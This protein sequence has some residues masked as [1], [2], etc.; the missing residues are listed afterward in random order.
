MRILYLVDSYYPDVRSPTR[1]SRDLTVE[2][3]TQGH[4]VTLMTPSSEQ[5]AALAI[6]QVD[7]VTIVRVRAGR[8][9]GV[10]RLRRAVN[11]VR[12]SAVLWR[13]AEA[14]FRANPHDLVISYSPTIFFGDLVRRLKRLW[15]ARSYLILRDIF[16]QWAA[17]AGILSER[18]PIYRFFAAK[19]EYQYRQADVIGVQSRGDL[20]F[21]R[22]MPHRVEVLY[23][24]FRPQPA[25][26]SGADWRARYGVP[27]RFVFFY[28]GNIGAAQNLDLVVRLAGEL[29]ADPRAYFL[30]VGEGSEAAR[31]QARIR[32][33]G[34]GNIA[35]HPPIPEADYF[36]VLAAMDV[37]LVSLDPRLRNHNFPAKLFGYMAASKPVLAA[38]NAGHELFDLL[39]DAGAGLGAAAEDFPLLSS[40]ARRLIEDPP[41]ARQI[42]ARARQLLASRFS[43]EAAVRQI[44][45]GARATTAEPTDPGRAARAG[46]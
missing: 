15:G 27:D 44:V 3:A 35:I 26:R 12:L 20:P 42:G 18:S 19:A 29:K 11:E 13:R 40:H 1:L 17:D 8:T 6:E 41:A 46:G 4:Q 25:E 31:L 34:L 5:T 39:G 43:V 45:G 2:L 9:K 23:N 37:G 21:F 14:F 32:E 30:L 24:W 36:E 38:L 16:P 33:L 28:G 10:N 7:G 22:G